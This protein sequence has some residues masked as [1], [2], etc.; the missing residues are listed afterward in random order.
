MSNWAILLGL[1]V[2]I[3][4][5]RMLAGGTPREREPGENPRRLRSGW[6]GCPDGGARIPPPPRWATRR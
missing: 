6:R 4:I 1:F 3:L 2:L 5:P